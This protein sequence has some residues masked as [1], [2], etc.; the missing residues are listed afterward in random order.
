MQANGPAVWLVGVTRHSIRVESWYPAPAGPQNCHGA[1]KV[2]RSF[3]K[4]WYSVINPGFTVYPFNSG[5]KTWRII[6]NIFVTV[7]MRWMCKNCDELINYT[8]R[9]SCSFVLKYY[10]QFDIF[11]LDTISD[12]R[13]GN[14]KISFQIFGNL[15][16]CDFINLHV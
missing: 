4:S 13:F 3:C 8:V 5:Q 6:E 1:R 16:N 12:F 14:L 7:A 2:R 10:W 15:S 9:V 11:G